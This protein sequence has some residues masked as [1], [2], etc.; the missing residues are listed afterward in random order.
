MLKLFYRRVAETLRLRAFL[1]PSVIFFPPLSV[2]VPLCLKQ[3]GPSAV[4]R[5]IQTFKH[6]NI[7]T[8]PQLELPGVWGAIFSGDIP[9]TDH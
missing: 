9:L 4:F 8:F 5:F 2:F 7:Q 6:S 1:T 3:R